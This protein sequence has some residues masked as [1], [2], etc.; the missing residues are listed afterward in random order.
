VSSLWY[1][2]LLVTGHHV[3]L[4]TTVVGAL[5]FSCFAAAVRIAAARKPERTEPERKTRLYLQT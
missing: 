2:L 5:F 1:G 3:G 4:Y